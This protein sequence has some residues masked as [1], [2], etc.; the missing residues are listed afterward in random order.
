MAKNILQRALSS[1]P[2]DGFTR[3]KKLADLAIKT[4][5]DSSGSPTP[6]GYELAL[7]YLQPFVDS[8]TGTEA[9]DSQRLIASYG[10]SLDKLSQ[11]KKDQSETVA[12]F[13]LQEL[14]SFFTSADGDVG[15]FR[16]PV[17]LIDATSESLDN[18]VLGVINAIDE[19]NSLGDSTDQ[20]NG[21]LNDLNKRADMMRD[22][23]NKSQSG[24]LTGKM[25]D[26]YGYYVDTNPLDG[27]IR[28][29]ALLP[30]GLA[31]EDLTKGYRRLEA[32]VNIGGA[33]MPV[34]APTTQ[35]SMG[36]YTAKVGDATWSGSGSGALQSKNA[37][38][39]K[40]LFAE[41]GFDISDQSM[42][43]VRKTALD[44]GS[45]GRGFLGKDKDGNPVES[46]FYRGTDNKLY[47]V[48]QATVDNFKKDP[49]LKRKLDGYVSQFSPSETKE[50]SREALPITEERL[51][52]ERRVAGFQLQAEEASAEADRAEGAG[53]FSN[54][55]EG[56][57]SVVSSIGN[58]LQ[59]TINV[60]QSSF[61]QNK[62]VPNKPDEFA[63]GGTP[64]NIVESGKQFFRKT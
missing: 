21:Y 50:L 63:T 55:K 60:K 15:S 46:V 44:R 35:D 37:V 31:P 38:K 20:L 48:D 1:V 32:T 18:L 10:N 4:N 33:L 43:P 54:L 3:A 34:Y 52:K 27:S 14:D 49:I 11:K 57:K 8:S 30:A 42:F 45:F 58:P 40:N 53:F 28:S 22:L 13:K 47:S 5:T 16:N 12:A 61:F 26:G 6:R 17:S 36:E 51:G 29:A 62:N 24:E 23:R 41:G 59:K 39:S 7:S 19:K 9:I 25:L 64:E 56:F 2:N